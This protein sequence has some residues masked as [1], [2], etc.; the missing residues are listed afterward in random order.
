MGAAVQPCGGSIMS[1]LS[2]YWL[3]LG[4]GVEV[5][6][7]LD[8]RKGEH[9]LREEVASAIA[10]LI[11]PYLHHGITR[12]DVIRRARPIKEAGGG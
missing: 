2:S 1:R 12:E 8:L 7:L 4:L 3:I 6:M 11:G 9:L 5:N 10:G